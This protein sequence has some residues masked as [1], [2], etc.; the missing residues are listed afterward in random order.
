VARERRGGAEKGAVQD[1]LEKCTNSRALTFRSASK[2]R[3]KNAAKEFLNEQKHFPPKR[4]VAAGAKKTKAL[5][6]AL[7]G[8]LAPGRKIVYFFT[9]SRK[10]ARKIRPNQM[11]DPPALPG[12]QSKF[13]GSGNQW[14]VN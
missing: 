8:V 7:L 4:Q 13:D 5:F 3:K 11:G 10:S 14:F 9:A 12:R 6:L 1:A 2:E